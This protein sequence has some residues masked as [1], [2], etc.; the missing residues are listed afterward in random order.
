MD[1]TDKKIG[2]ELRRITHTDKKDRFPVMSGVV[3][4]G[5][6]DLEDMTCD[7]RLSVD[8]DPSDPDFMP[9]PAIQITAA[10]ESTNGLVLYPADNSQVWVAEIDG[11]GKWGL[12]KC[13]DLV[14]MQ[15][16]IGGSKVTVTDGLVQFN[17]GS[18]AGLVKVADL[19]T[20]L[21]NIENKINALINIFTTWT[22]LSGDGG[23]A[24]KTLLATWVATEL[25][26]TLQ[27]DI[28]NTAVKH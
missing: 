21:N 3:M 28:E 11:P 16:T 15:C 1:K 12:V 8:L 17:D 14:K 13:S 5:S 27:E 23:A 2:D 10:L 4:E 24:L 25:T 20:K 18:N 22:P 26:D 19:K 9:T 7:V 6:T